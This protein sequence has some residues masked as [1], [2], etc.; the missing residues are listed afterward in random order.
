MFFQ[1]ISLIYNPKSLVYSQQKY[2]IFFKKNYIKKELNLNKTSLKFHELNRYTTNSIF[3]LNNII[4]PKFSFFFNIKLLPTLFKFF[5][6]NN[7]K[8]NNFLINLQNF[9]NDNAYTNLIPC[10]SSFKYKLA[11]NLYF[12][13]L[14][15][16]FREN[17]TPWI[18]NTLIRFFEYNSGKK[19]LLDIYSFMNQSL[20]LKYIILY[21]SWL[22]KFSYY[23]RR[24]GHRF[25]LEEALHIIHMSFNYQD[26]KLLS[27]WLKSLIQRISFWKTRFIFRFIK[28]LFDNYMQFLFKEIGIKG[29]KLKL[30]G[31]I[32]VAGNSRKRCILYRIGKTSH[33]QCNL[34]VVH[35]MDTIT[36]FTGVMGFQVWIFY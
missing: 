36:T 25:F 23:E 7:F 19:V 16:S 17:V 4:L 18:Y 21:K 15:S 29:F 27:S 28:Y 14:N 2:N 26:S 11:K 10:I 35:T 34:K 6:F 30:K 24:L 9:S 33:A 12:A 22:A 5:Y 31:K 32:S 1:K 20:D 8:K 13:Q 3:K